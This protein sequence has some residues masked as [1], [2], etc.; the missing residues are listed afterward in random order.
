[1]SSNSLLLSRHLPFE[2][3]YIELQIPNLLTLKIFQYV[4][5]LATSGGNW[6]MP[7]T[8]NFKNLRMCQTV[9]YS[10]HDRGWAFWFLQHDNSKCS[11]RITNSHYNLNGHKLQIYSYKILALYRYLNRIYTFTSYTIRTCCMKNNNQALLITT[12]N[13]IIKQWNQNALQVWLICHFIRHI[14]SK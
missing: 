11:M 2:S 7:S 13:K 4:T 6:R 10:E 5:L 9:S 14:Y 8:V 12:E 1:M 3:S